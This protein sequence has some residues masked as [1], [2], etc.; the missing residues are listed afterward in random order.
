MDNQ[1]NLEG[2]RL[3]HGVGILRMTADR[4][5]RLRIPAGLVLAGEMRETQNS[6]G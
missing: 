4:D 5:I 3:G 1:R 6:K 2:F